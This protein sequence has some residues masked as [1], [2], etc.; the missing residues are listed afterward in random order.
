MGKSKLNIDLV[1][2]TDALIIGRRLNQKKI[3]NKRILK[4]PLSYKEIFFEFLSETTCHGLPFVGNRKISYFERFFFIAVI[5]TVLCIAFSFI[6]DVYHTWSKTPVVIQVHNNATEVTEFPFPAITV[7]NKN[8]ALKSKVKDMKNDTVEFGIL[9]MLCTRYGE[10]D[11]KKIN[12]E[13]PSNDNIKIFNDTIMKI[14]QPCDRLIVQC[15]QSSGNV[16]C[17]KLFKP[18]ITDEGLCCTYNSLHPKFMLQNYRDTSDST[19]PKLDKIMPI[20]WSTET[21]YP[22]DLPK[23]FYPERIAGAGIYNGLTITLDAEVDEYYCSSTDGSGVKFNVHSPA[24]TSSIR[25]IGFTIGT[26]VDLRVKLAPSYTVTAENVRNI[27]PNVRGCLYNNDVNLTY[28]RTYTTKNAQTECLS[29][30][31]YKVCGCVPFYVPRVSSH[32]TYCELKEMRCI[33]DFLNDPSYDNDE[34]E[35]YNFM[36][37][38]FD[39]NYIATLYSAEIYHTSDNFST[40]TGGLVSLFLGMSSIT[41]VEIFY[42][43]ILKYFF[44]KLRERRQKKTIGPKC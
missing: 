30:K 36:P 8:Q 1:L 13:S 41:F 43:F 37:G 40:K 17:N 3:I 27:D 12:Y 33:Y 6:I 25:E 2:S 42:F 10:I 19:I 15:S 26:R 5:I 7:C 14:A 32:I 35:C 34:L 44:A 4:K 31:F 23:K 21:G 29:S 16:E 20:D 9:Q 38:C 22:D 24:E 28:F 39:L 18:V 11:F